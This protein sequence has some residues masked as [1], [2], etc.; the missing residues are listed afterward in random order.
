MLASPEMS[1]AEFTQ[2]ADR[3]SQLA[4]AQHLGDL[5]AATGEHVSF[6]AHQ[7]R[8]MSVARSQC[9]VVDSD[10]LILS[11]LWVNA[12]FT[13]RSHNSERRASHSSSFSATTTTTTTTTFSSTG[14]TSGECSHNDAVAYAVLCAL[15]DHALTD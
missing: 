5:A 15:V 1:F 3:R 12:S 2:V 4:A 11:P 13:S 10:S 8:I 14:A 6:S 7:A 9:Q